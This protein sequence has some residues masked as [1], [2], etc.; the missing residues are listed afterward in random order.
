V[1][2]AGPPELILGVD[3]GGGPHV[4]VLRYTPGTAGNVTPLL[5]FF[6]Y[7]PGFRGGIRVAAGDV[8]GSGRASIILGAGAG[9]GPHV[10]ALKY[11]GGGSLVEVASFMVY[12]LGF[13]AGIF[14][15][16]GD[17][18]GD[19]K[20]DI[21]TGVGPGGGP[22]VRAVTLGPGGVPVELASFFAYDP[23]AR[24]GMRVG[25][26]RLNPGDA[27]AAILTVPGPGSGAHVKAFRRNGDGS[28]TEVT[29]FF[30]YP[31][32]FFGGV[33]IAGVQ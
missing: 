21:I 13:L 25:A 16:A 33:F 17:V 23:G 5:D 27:Q 28:V 7:D 1:D 20:A 3:A 4:R 22:H 8:D 12:D 19:G 26:A 10:R 24:S 31:G 2:G 32:T 14:V 15:A 29:S 6:A 18:N 11:A 30:A 9:G